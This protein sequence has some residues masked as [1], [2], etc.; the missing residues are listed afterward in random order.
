M[1][2][3]GLQQVREMPR[4]ASGLAEVSQKRSS[5][6]Y[7]CSEQLMARR[8]GRLKQSAVQGGEGASKLC[9][10]WTP[11]LL[12]NKLSSLCT[13][14]CAAPPVLPAERGYDMVSAP[15]SLYD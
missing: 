7:L 12:K 8:V 14:H 15:A 1:A 5:Y 10:L 2:A 6:S 11:L 13:G 3:M 4:W 9:L